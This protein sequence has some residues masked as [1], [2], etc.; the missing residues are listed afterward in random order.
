[1]RVVF[2]SLHFLLLP[3]SSGCDCDECKRLALFRI[4]RA[5]VSTTRLYEI[6]E[7]SGWPLHQPPDKYH[8][9]LGRMTHLIADTASGEVT[10]IRGNKGW[11]TIMSGHRDDDA[12][13]LEQMAKHGVHFPI[14][15]MRPIVTN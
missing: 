2:H 4:T 9:D 5:K 13:V 6:A 7:K 10:F 11:C 15:F 8:H 1:M 3:M 14:S 12:E